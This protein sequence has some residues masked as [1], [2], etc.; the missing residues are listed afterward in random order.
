[1]EPKFIQAYIRHTELSIFINVHEIKSFQEDF[2]QGCIV[3]GKELDEPFAEI[4]S[5]IQASLSGAETFRLYD[6]YKRVSKI[7]SV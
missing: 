1:M 7:K 6:R 5:R 4:M 3:D 2:D